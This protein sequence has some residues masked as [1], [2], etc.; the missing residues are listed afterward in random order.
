[1]YTCIYVY[2]GWQCKG[3]F[4]LWVDI[5]KKGVFTT[6]FT[7]LHSQHLEGVVHTCVSTSS[8]STETGLCPH[9]YSRA[10]FLS[11]LSHSSDPF[12]CLS[13]SSLWPL[14]L[15]PGYKFHL[16]TTLKTQHFVIIKVFNEKVNS[17]VTPSEIITVNIL[18]IFQL[19]ICMYF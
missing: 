16:P 9:C 17:P 18:F 13:L 1:M 15:L 10:A 19:D 3:Y 14:T 5:W 8:Y 4:L 7:F 2:T 12:L 6:L 11:K